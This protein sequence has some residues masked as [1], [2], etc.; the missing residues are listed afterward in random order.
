ML[1]YPALSPEERDRFV[2]E[3]I[4]LS[5]DHRWAWDVLIALCEQELARDE[6]PGPDWIPI[7]DG[8]RQLAPPPWPPAPDLLTRFAMEVATEK[9]KHPDKRRGR[10]RIDQRLTA[11]QTFAVETLCQEHGFKVTPARKLVAEWVRMIE[12]EAIRKR[13]NK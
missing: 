6:G 8:V 1:F 2:R 10:P 11:M 3:H 5:E 9:R 4:R 7:G 12:G 13:T